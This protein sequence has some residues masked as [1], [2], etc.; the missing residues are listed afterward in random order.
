MIHSAKND[1]MLR[2]S[3]KLNDPSTGP[4]SYWT[5]FNWFVNNKKDT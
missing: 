5:I 4:I 1:Y 3:K 2:M